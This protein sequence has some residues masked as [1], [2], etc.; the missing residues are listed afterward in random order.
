MPIAEIAKE[1]EIR[2]DLWIMKTWKVLPTDPRYL[3]LTEEQRELLW[4]DFLIDHPEIREEINKRGK[5]YDDDFDELWE[6]LDK[7]ENTSEGDWEVIEDTD[8][9]VDA[10]SDN[11]KAF[12]E[13]KN[14]DI[15]YDPSVERLLKSSPADEWEEVDD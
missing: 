3:D 5:V 6:S 15:Q 1:P 9:D 10:V 7:L 12:I 2:F 13:E 8:V 4:E 14:L 11:F